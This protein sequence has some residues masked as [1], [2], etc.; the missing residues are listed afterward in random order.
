MKQW[1]EYLEE[2]V[3]PD[4]IDIKNISVKDTLDPIIWDDKQRI[5][6]YLAEHLY[7]IAKDFFKVLGLDWSLVEDV[8]LTG[9]LANYNWSNFSDV[10]LHLIVDYSDVDDNE[11]LVRDFFRN[12][13]AVWN[14]THHIT[15]KGHDVELYVQDS[16]EPHHSTGVYSIKYDRWNNVPSKYDPQIDEVNIRKKAAK[17]MNDVDEVHDLYAEKDYKSANEQS[18]RLMK[19]L[20]KYRQGGLEKGGEYSIEN[21]VF[22]VLR[23]NDYLQRLSSLRI[24]SYDNMMTVNGGIGSEIIKVN[25]NET[26]QGRD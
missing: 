26:N 20:K 2:I 16:R 5:K 17:W 23:R 19:K 1:K 11:N 6:S 9:S 4:D 8:T 10:D 25:L 14:R 18:E 7:K 12:A 24:M 21:L 3:D 13:S 22:K 15:V